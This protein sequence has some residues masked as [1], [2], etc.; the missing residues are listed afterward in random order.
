MRIA[1]TIR[2]MIVLTAAVFSRCAEDS[3]RESYRARH[4]PLTVLAGCRITHLVHLYRRVPWATRRLIRLTT[5][6][7]TQEA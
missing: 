3:A 2:H 1:L 6:S 5:L 7:F 4:G